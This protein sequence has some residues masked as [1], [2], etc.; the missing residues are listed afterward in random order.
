MF[1]LMEVNFNSL[2][3]KTIQQNNIDCRARCEELEIEIMT[4]AGQ[5][6][7]VQYRFIKLLA[8]FDDNGG[9]HGDGINYFALW[10]NWKIG[11]GMMM[12]REKVRVARSLADLPLIDKAFSE[13][14]ISYTK[15]RAMTRGYARK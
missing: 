7:A 4:L 15:V 10:L 2:D 9:W 12:G 11:M 1:D 5:M 8:E 13:G 3:I 6:N 14:K